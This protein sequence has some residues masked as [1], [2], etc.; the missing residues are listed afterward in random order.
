MAAEWSVVWSWLEPV[1][2]A[3]AGEDQGRHATDRYEALRRI[4]RKAAFD[5]GVGQ[6]G[7]DVLNE[8]LTRL[9]DILARKP[10]LMNLPQPERAAY[11][12]AIVRNV[13]R[14]VGRGERRFVQQDVE[15]ASVSSDDDENLRKERSE[16]CLTRCLEQ[17]DPQSQDLLRQY[18]QETGPAHR[19]ALAL[20][21]GWGINRLRVWIHRE[22]ERLRRCQEDCL[23]NGD[24]FQ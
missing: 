12:R 8:V 4:C 2:T 21:L 23:R 5:G 13:V 10:E 20:R 16:A 6:H 1:D 22:R 18:Y 24:A 19:K 9:P 15:S 3:R 7:D 14:E 11:M 17:A